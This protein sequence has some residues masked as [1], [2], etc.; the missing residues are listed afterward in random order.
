M[1][2]SGGQGL[3]SGSAAADPDHLDGDGGGF[4]ADVVP[5][6]V[7]A[8]GKGVVEGVGRE[9]AEHGRDPGV[10]AD[11]HDPGRALAGDVLEVSGLTA[12][13]AAETDHGVVVTGGG[14]PLGGEGDLEGPRH[15][16]LGDV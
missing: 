6:D 9:H 11:A 13:H 14:Q 16:D 12:D 7:I 3:V 2:A 1:V 15:P 8:A 4:L 5:T 10:E